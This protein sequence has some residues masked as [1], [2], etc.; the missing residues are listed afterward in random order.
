MERKDTNSGVST[1]ETEKEQC[2]S[3]N[4]TMNFTQLHF[5][6][7]IAMERSSC[8]RIPEKKKRLAKLEKLLFWP[9]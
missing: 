1:Q 8:G 5:A 6:L 4:F 7:H 9:M 3:R 2:K